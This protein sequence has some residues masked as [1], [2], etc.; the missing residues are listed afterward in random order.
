MSHGSSGVKSVKSREADGTLKETLALD[1][2]PQDNTTLEASRRPLER[3]ESDIDS[4][5]QKRALLNQQAQEGGNEQR[6]GAADIGN[7]L[8]CSSAATLLL[9]RDFKIRFFTRSTASLFGLLGSDIGRPLAHLSLS[10]IDNH[11][12]SDSRSVLDNLL[13]SRREV[14]PGNDLCLMRK[15]DPYR[16]EDGRVSGVVVTFS[17]ITELKLVEREIQAARSVSESVID[18][19]R[20]P[21]IVFDKEMSVYCVNK[22]LCELFGAT[23]EHCVGR[24]LSQTPARV[25]V[26]IAESVLRSNAECRGSDNQESFEV[27]SSSRGPLK[28]QTTT[29]LIPGKTPQSDMICLLLEDVTERV[30]I[31]A[32]NR[33]LA[34]SNIWKSHFLAAASHDLRQPLQTLRLLCAVLKRKLSDDATLALTAKLEAT[35]DSMT[36]LINSILDINQLE[37]GAIKPCIQCF[38]ASALLDTL[39]DE[40]DVLVKAKG[41]TWRI[42]MSDAVLKTD[43]RL[44]LQIMRNLIGN[45]IKFADSGKLLLCCRNRGDAVRL[46]IWDSGPGIPASDLTNIFGLFQKGQASGCVADEGFGLGLAIVKALSEILDLKVE[47]VSRPGTGSRFS[48]L[49]PRGEQQGQ[50]NA[51]AKAPLREPLDLSDF[52]I[53]VVDDDP[54]VRESLALLFAAEG[55]ATAEAANRITAVQI[56]ESGAFSPDFIIVDYNL[57]GA[58]NGLAIIDEVRAALGRE[59]PALVLTGDISSRAAATICANAVLHFI[60]PVQPEELLRAIETH[61]RAPSLITSTPADTSPGEKAETPKDDEKAKVFIVDDDD[62]VREA[63]RDLL[64]AFGYKVEAFSS[65]RDFIESGCCNSNG[66]LI[67]DACM[68]GMDGFEILKYIR[69]R[70]ASVPVIMIT[71]Q[72]DVRTAV[73]AMKAGASDFIEKPVD[74][75]QLRS[76]V[77]RALEPPQTMIRK[78]AECAATDAVARL[79]RRQRAVLDCVVAGDPNKVIANKLGIGQRTV[80]SHRATAMR[81]LG[82]RTFADLIRLL[83]AADMNANAPAHLDDER[84]IHNDPSGDSFQQ[85]HLES[86]EIRRLP[87]HCEDCSN[88]HP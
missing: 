60:K 14:F 71:G 65:G 20:E 23:A 66:C 19:V 8:N 34:Q 62:N 79:T 73:R 42:L 64:D 11:L 44:L 61:A 12:L 52:R 21:L 7:I 31:E 36:G 80:E 77:E 81:K 25:L 1:D 76:S 27:E 82:V 45:A 3:T 87:A 56:V 43:R 46:E 75:E 4:L 15:I 50:C 70:Q 85:C 10:M 55:Y 47:V 29:R 41:L 17:D 2:V 83:I 57:S 72:G 59:V 68:P 74:P 86:S 32:A 6:R 49:V 51:V 38:P 33:G 69:T 13:S 88:L 26:A 39:A 78:P 48:V 22:A 9:D 28:L 54:K 58:E 5:D 30:K 37:A 84:C 40:F 63:L 67:L 24:H 35:V 16:S 53:L 18:S